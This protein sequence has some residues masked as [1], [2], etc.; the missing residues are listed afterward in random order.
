MMS[1]PTSDKTAHRRPPHDRSAALKAL[2]CDARAEALFESLAPDQRVVGVIG[3]READAYGLQLAHAL[4]HQAVRSGALVISGG[5]RGIDLAAHSAALEGAGQSVAVIACGLERA[6]E[7]LCSLQELG[8]GL[9]SPFEPQVPPA[10][11]RFAA[12]NAH[13][14]SLCDVL[15]VAQAG[16]KSGSLITARHALKLGRE[17]WV[18]PGPLQSPHEG[19]YTLL[20]EGA[21]LLTSDEAWLGGR[22]Q[23]REAS[24]EASHG[25]RAPQVN[26]MKARF[27]A[28]H[29]RPPAP[30]AP[31]G[32]PPS[33]ALW[34]AAE[35]TP[36]PLAELAARAELPLSKALSEATLLELEGWL[37]AAPGGCFV[38][39]EPSTSS[40]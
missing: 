2:S 5:A 37:I 40:A 20:S 39:V 35:L 11:W 34:R 16:L 18:A 14:A 22:T 9:V 23:G 10:R 24:H 36:Q 28:P 38:R 19:C 12:R 26:N 27:K 7:R 29:A 6:P 33:S 13:I 15:I 31:P 25:A 32:P 3:A 17:V 4:A 21:R 8:L 30:L 1:T